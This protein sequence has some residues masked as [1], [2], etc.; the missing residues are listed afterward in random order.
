MKL[1]LTA[2]LLAGSLAAAQLAAGAAPHA[3]SPAPDAQEVL[4][5]LTAGNHRFAAGR[6][7]RP[8]AEPARVRE[9]GTRGQHP[10]AVVLACADS[11][12]CPEILFDQGVGDLFT[13]RVAGNVANE[14]E[15]ASV[16][17]AAEH[18]G[19][20]VCVVL[21]H[22]G[23]GAVTAV[24]KGEELHGSFDHL[25]APTREA[26]AALRKSRPELS[27]QVL[28]DEAIRANVWEAIQDLLRESPAVAARLRAGKL[29]IVGALY[30]T[31]TG[32]VRWLG[33]HPREA[34][35]LKAAG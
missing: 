25:L 5:A 32:T 23:C 15:A 35:L 30:D 16:E 2:A 21:G 17:Y 14:D 8:H 9:T 4:A 26:V 22:A 10:R 6:A 34:S 11:R 7:A 1:P 12:V 20:P 19:V 13:I 3:G 33:R 31:R 29:R 27:G 18:L 24:V 28:L